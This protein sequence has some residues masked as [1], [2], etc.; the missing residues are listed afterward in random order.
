MNQAME[1]VVLPQ[2]VEVNTYLLNPG[3]LNH[4]TKGGSMNTFILLYVLTMADGTVHS[5]YKEAAHANHYKRVK[6]MQQCSLL[7]EEQQRRLMLGV[8]GTSIKHVKVTCVY[9]KPK[10]TRH[11]VK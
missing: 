6:D 2:A 5:I 9:G 3:R 7:A 8:E 4:L 1:V 10:V 11:K